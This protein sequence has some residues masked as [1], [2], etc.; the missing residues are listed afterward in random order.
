MTA[1]TVRDATAADH[2][3]ILALNLESVDLMSPMDAQR[4][5]E[6]DREAAYHRAVCDGDEVVG[7]LLALREGAAYDSPNYLWFGERYP[8]FLYVDRIAVAASHRGRRLGGLLYD[9]LFGF[10][11]DGGFERIACEFYIVPFNQASSRF[12]ARY[13]FAEVGT[14]WVAEGRK[15]VSLQIAPVAADA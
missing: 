13:G 4:L 1:L 2:P 11:R 5:R 3:A 12:H 7:F 6:L 15:Q 9:D 14:Q 10:A 8:A